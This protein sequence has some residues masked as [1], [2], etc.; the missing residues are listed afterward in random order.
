VLG[1]QDVATLKDFAAAVADV[2]A[3]ATGALLPATSCEDDLGLSTLQ[4]LS[5]DDDAPRSGGPVSGVMAASLKRSDG[6]ICS[7]MGCVIAAA[8]A[9]VI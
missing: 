1:E 8:D 4:L 9:F 2:E 5:H 6:D 7:C 3:V